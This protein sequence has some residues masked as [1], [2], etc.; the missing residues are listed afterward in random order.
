MR[1]S[2]EID[3]GCRQRFVHRHQKISGAQ[4]AALFDPRAFCNG[5]AERDADV[6]DG[7][8]LIDVEIAFRGNVRSNAP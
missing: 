8:V 1:T 4:N 5:F 3:R 6:F 2:A 7:V